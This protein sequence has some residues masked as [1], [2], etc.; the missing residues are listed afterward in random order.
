MP[1]E[2]PTVEQ[3]CGLE[4]LA[5]Y[6]IPSDWQDEN[7]HVNV[8]YYQFLYEIGGWPMLEPIGVD[9]SYFTQRKRGIFD[10]EHHISYL[11]ELHVGERVTMHGRFLAR[12]A[13]RM[14]GM[15]FV[16]NADRNALACVLEFLSTGANLE[17]RRT[18]VF[19]DDIAAGLDQ[20]IEADRAIDWP[21]PVCGAMSV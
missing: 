2:F 1:R 12:N 9:I 18:D 21:A 15:L 11:R 16:V 20:L 13:K 19:P 17:T 4:T 8:K 5:E 3:V 10:L 14:H 7:G 6:T